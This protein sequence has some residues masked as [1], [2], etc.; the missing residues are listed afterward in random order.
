MGIKCVKEDVYTYDLLLRVFIGAEQVDRLHVAKVDIVAEKED[1]EQLAD[2]LLL[3]VTIQSFIS[4]KLG[5]D[6]RQL[7]VNTLDFSLFTLT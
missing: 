7:L 3:T 4:F 5:A 6:V 1:E 2:V